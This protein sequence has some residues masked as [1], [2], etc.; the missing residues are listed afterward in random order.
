MAAEST[1]N[2]F[3]LNDPP[4]DGISA[5]KFSPTS[6]NFLI[7]SSWDKVSISTVIFVVGIRRKKV[8]AKNHHETMPKRF[9]VFLGLK[10][11]GAKLV[12]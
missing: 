5:V 2:E 3:K 8:R 9:F 4:S 12:W 1:P 11:V 7:A 6:S 10:K